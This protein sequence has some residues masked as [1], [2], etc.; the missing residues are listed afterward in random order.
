VYAQCVVCVYCFHNKLG[1]QCIHW[2]KQNM[3]IAGFFMTDD[4]YRCDTCGVAKSKDCFFKSFIRDARF[5][6]KSCV[7]HLRELTSGPF[8][9]YDRI[10]ATLRKLESGMLLKQRNEAMIVGDPA[11]VQRK[12]FILSRENIVY[13]VSNIW[14]NRSAVSD[15]PFDETHLMLARWDIKKPFCPEN[16]ILLTAEESELHHQYQAEYT[17]GRLVLYGSE[18]CQRIETRLQQMQQSVT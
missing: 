9:D 12:K 7:A 15:T 14:Q 16:S 2:S 1:M 13:L 3:R 6:C 8:K 4:K 10:A 18:F 17:L 5:R 11:R